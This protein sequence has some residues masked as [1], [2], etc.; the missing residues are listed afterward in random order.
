MVKYCNQLQ[1]FLIKRKCTYLYSY[2][3]VSVLNAPYNEA[4][5]FCGVGYPNF[6]HAFCGPCNIHHVRVFVAQKMFGFPRHEKA[7]RGL[8]GVEKGPPAI[9]LVIALKVV[10]GHHV[11]V[12]Q[13]RVFFDTH[14][15]GGACPGRKYGLSNILSA[16][17]K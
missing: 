9:R 5:A 4:D 11:V 2:V 14:K 7:L 3:C 15:S 10:V 13:N 6:Q 12:F 8:R 17:E 16:K 1:T